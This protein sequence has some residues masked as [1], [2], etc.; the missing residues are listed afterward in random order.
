MD[1]A[2]AETG[3]ARIYAQE[4]VIDVSITARHYATNGPKLLAD[5]KVKGVVA[6]AGVGPNIGS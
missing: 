4:E 2:Q 1:I 5:R 3:K 6:T